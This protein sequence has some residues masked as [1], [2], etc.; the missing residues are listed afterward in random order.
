V[1]LWFLLPRDSAAISGG[2]LY[3]LGILAALERR[4]AAVRASIDELEALLD[5]RAPGVYLLDSLDL[6]RASLLERRAPGQRFG[7]LVHHLPSLEPGL[8]PASPLLDVERRTLPLFDFLVATSEYTRQLLSARGFAAD[9]V[10]SVPPGLE[11]VVRIPRSITTPLRVA[12]VGNLIPRKG[13]RELLAG[14]SSRLGPADDFELSIVGR[15]DHDPDYAR[16][17]RAAVSASSALE[18]SVRFRGALAPS[19]MPG[20]YLDTALLVSASSMET[21]GIALQEARA[22]GVPILALDR[23]NAREHVSAG[24]NGW[25]VESVEALSDTLVALVRAPERL[26]AVFARA[27]ALPAVTEG[28]DVVVGRF[29]AWLAGVD[30]RSEPS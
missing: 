11:P 10:V 23:G 1:K 24:V 7:L 17:C 9:R 29:L 22:H 25:L 3:N 8:D 21:F 15:D 5:S 26:R 13:V 28:W 20:V 19:E 6:E 18:R 14:L 30:R 27:Q 2:N 16:A 12:L 4:S